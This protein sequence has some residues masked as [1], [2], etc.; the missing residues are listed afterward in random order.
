MA[1]PREFN[2]DQAVDQAVET[3]WDLGY[4]STSTA[5]LVDRLGIA[6]SSLY[7]AFGSKDDL[8]TE[9]MDRYIEGL[10]TRAIEPLRADGPAMEVLRDFFR[11]AAVRWI[12]EGERLRCCMVVRASLAGS[13]QPPAIRQRTRQAIAELDDAFYA[14]LRRARDEESLPP[15]LGLRGTA[16]FLT[17]TYQALNIAALAGRDRRE[18]REIVDCALATLAPGQGASQ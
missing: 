17:T 16:R 10:R 14:L 7:A 3:F 5:V 9:A 18:L 2:R 13:D 12:P 6:K 15:S 4:E 1:R 8:Y 11:R